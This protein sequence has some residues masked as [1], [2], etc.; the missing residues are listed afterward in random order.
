MGVMVVMELTHLDLLQQ[1]QV[2][3]VVAEVQ[4]K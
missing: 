2:L 4:G 1:V 3:A